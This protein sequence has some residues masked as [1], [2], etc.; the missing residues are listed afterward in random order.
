MASDTNSSIGGYSRIYVNQ[1]AKAITE[2]R[3]LAWALRMQ[4]HLV[5]QAAVAGRKNEPRR[6][7]DRLSESGKG[8]RT[9][10]ASSFVTP[11]MQSMSI[12]VSGFD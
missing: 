7:H 6:L 3:I 12:R 9:E 4:Y 2:V 1:V 8:L 11:A 10:A 5:Q